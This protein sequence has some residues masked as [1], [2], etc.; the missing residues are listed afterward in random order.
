[1]KYG[2]EYEAVAKQKFFDYM[3]Y[4]LKRNVMIRETG[5]VVQPNLF[6]LGASP[7][8]L[9]FDSLCEEPILIEIKCPYSKRHLSPSELLQDDKFYVFEKNDVTYLKK[10]HHFG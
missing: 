1:M 3:T 4:V 10:D 6:W 2:K 7:D 9:F 5:L 8:G